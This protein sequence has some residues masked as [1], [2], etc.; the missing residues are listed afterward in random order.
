MKHPYIKEIISELIDI[1]PK[2]ENDDFYLWTLVCD[3]YLG[4]DADKYPIS[5]IKR[6]LRSLGL[7][8]LKLC[9]RTRKKIL[10]ERGGYEW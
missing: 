1:E 6:D 5:R 7:P 9:I 4:A 8:S 3:A 2:A 10:E